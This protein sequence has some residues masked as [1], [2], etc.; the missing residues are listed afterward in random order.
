MEVTLVLGDELRNL[1]TGIRTEI[2][3][4]KTAPQPQAPKI[5]TRSDVAKMFGV[6]LVTVHSWMDAGILPFYK[7]NGKTYFKE[8]EVLQSMKQVKI[9]RKHHTVN[10]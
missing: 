3:Q 4:L 8:D 5:L 6:T 1:L 9:K 2:N 10:S 7:M